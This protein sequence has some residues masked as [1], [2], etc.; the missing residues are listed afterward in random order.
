MMGF[1]KNELVDILN[2]QDIP[3]EEQEEI[4]PIMKESYDGYKFSLNAKNQIYNSNIKQRLMHL[5]CGC[6][7]FISRKSIYER[8]QQKSNAELYC[9]SGHISV[10]RNRQLGKCG[11]RN[12]G[13]SMACRGHHF[14]Q[15][16][17]HN[18][19]SCEHA[20]NAGYRRFGR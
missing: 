18:T 20:Y 5:I 11:N 16:A 7:N 2:N 14:N 6:K 1:T 19:V 12:H 9:H 4:L 3:K 15:N 13:S 10:F 8:Q 17:R